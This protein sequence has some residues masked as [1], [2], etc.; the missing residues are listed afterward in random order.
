MDGYGYGDLTEL[1]ITEDE[2]D[3][4]DHEDYDGRLPSTTGRIV[5]DDGGDRPRGRGGS[6]SRT[7]GIVLE[8]GEDCLLG[9]RLTREKDYG[10]SDGWRSFSSRTRGRTC[11]RNS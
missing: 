7:R 3:D 5:L 2:L 10:R 11:S 1:V 9:V 8:D 4:D 6:S